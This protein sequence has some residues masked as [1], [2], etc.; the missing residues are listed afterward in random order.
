MIDFTIS[1]AGIPVGVSAFSPTTKDFCRD[2]LTDAEPELSVTITKEDILAEEAYSAL[3]DQRKGLPRHYVSPEYAETL[4]LYRK[5]SV[6]LLERDTVVFHGSAVALNGRAYIFTAPSGTGK[7]THTRLWLENIEGSYVL[8]GDKP[9]LRLDGERTLVCGTPWQG[10]ENYGCSEILPLEA[11]CIL[12]RS[13]E[14]RIE[15]ITLGD[16]LS[17]LVRQTHAP[18]APDAVVKT[19]S[20]IGRIG[21][22]VRLY[23]LGCNMDPE[24]ARVSCRGMLY[25]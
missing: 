13:D 18:D 7:T 1:L 23:R 25:E 15:R 20:L 10:K 4:A 6:S 11:I 24:A 22:T 3:Q 14:N 17:T 5:I 12:E 8:N 21:G 16:A 19:A 2:Y 9:L